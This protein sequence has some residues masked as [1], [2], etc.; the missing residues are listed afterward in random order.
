MEK[1]SVTVDKSHLITIGERLYT[2]SVELLRELINNSYDADA[3]QVMV[4]IS[5]DE[6]T[7]ED[8]GIGMDIDGLKQYFNIGSPF[9]KENPKSPK[10]GRFRIGEFGIG[11]FSV[12]SNC[13]RFEVFTKKGDFAG[14][15]VFNKDEW[16]KDRGHW[17]LPFFQETPDNKYDGTKVTLRGLKKKFD[18]ETVE[19]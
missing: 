18:L 4:T 12:L 19:K 9:K 10:F 1:I 16:E 13:D 11:K 8:D 3:T 17:Q 7:V 5:D 14:R 2:E 6:V 15:V